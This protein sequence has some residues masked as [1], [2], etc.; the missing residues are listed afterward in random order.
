VRS[1]KTE[2]LTVRNKK[3]AIMTALYANLGPVLRLGA[4]YSQSVYIAYFDENKELSIGNI[5]IHGSAIGS[6]IDFCKGKDIYSNAIEVSGSTSAKK[7][8]T[9]Y[10][11][12]VFKMKEVSPETE[13]KAKDLDKQLQKY[14]SIYFNRDKKLDNLEPQRIDEDEILEP[15]D[16]FV[17]ENTD[18]SPDDL[19]F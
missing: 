9:K 3:G 12:P 15:I 10:F 6:W 19:P 14:F 16:T 5:S 7:G 13:N 17:G 1:T 8:A 4:C 2:P 11:V 18:Q